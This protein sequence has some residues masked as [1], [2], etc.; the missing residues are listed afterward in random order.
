MAGALTLTSVEAGEEK[1][2][3]TNSGAEPEATKVV[4]VCITLRSGVQ[5]PPPQQTGTRDP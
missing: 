1:V 5:F 2:Q 4:V 3:T